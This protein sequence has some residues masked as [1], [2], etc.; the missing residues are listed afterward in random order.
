M[1]NV[2]SLAFATSFA[3]AAVLPPMSLSICIRSGSI[4]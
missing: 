2:M 1:L 3:E 4:S